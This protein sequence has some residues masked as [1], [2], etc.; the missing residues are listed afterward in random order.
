MGVYIG[1]AIAVII[2]LWS[3]ITYNRLIVLQNRVRNNWSQ[4]D[5]VLKNRFDL[6]P[7]LVEAVAGYAAHERDTLRQLTEARTKYAAAKSVDDKAAA[8]GELS[9]V[10]QRLLAVA[11]NY[12]DLKASNNFM[13]LKEQLA[14]I[15]EKVRLSR[16][17][18]NDTVELF[19]TAIMT[20][21]TNMVAGLFGFREQAFFRIDEV[22]RINP[23]I[24][25]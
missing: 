6:I 9:G 2:V 24:K 11:E 16:Q 20:I 5:I 21:P 19:N 1:I 8:S 4:V 14:A 13:Y 17:F 23:Q 22:E 7:S 18:Y 25:F 15:E 10:L 12:P 3:I